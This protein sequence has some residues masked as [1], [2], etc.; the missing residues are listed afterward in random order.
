METYENQ[1]F[2]SLYAAIS[3]GQRD[4]DGGCKDSANGWAYEKWSIPRRHKM[5]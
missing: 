5:R 1:G 3:C 2:Q 4:A